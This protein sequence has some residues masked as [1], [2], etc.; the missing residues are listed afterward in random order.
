MIPFIVGIL[1]L[2][3]VF[4]IFH[5]AKAKK[6]ESVKTTKVTQM[7]GDVRKE[8]VVLALLTESDKTQI[9]AHY[10]ILWN[11]TP[12]KS[13][14][15]VITHDSLEVAKGEGT[16]SSSVFK[17]RGIPLEPGKIYDVKVG[18]TKVT[19]PFTP[20]LVT[21]INTIN[22]DFDV[23]TNIV[24]TNI[25]IIL[26]STKIPLRECQIKIEPPGFICKLPSHTENKPTMVIYNGQNAVN[27]LM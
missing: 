17:I 20:P 12:G 13:Y 24:P 2:V 9:Q 27:I 23:S 26:G 10:A 19:I 1:I 25:E 6:T 16:S 18:D 11:G 7:E 22:G 3:A 15:Y 21:G 8:D 14:E 4:V 5:F